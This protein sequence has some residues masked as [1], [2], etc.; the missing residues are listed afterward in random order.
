MSLVER[1]NDEERNEL[2]NKWLENVSEI[3]SETVSL[4]ID[5]DRLTNW[6][7]EN[8]SIVKYKDGT[9]K[10]DLSSRQ[11]PSKVYKHINSIMQSWG[12]ELKSIEIN[13]GGSFINSSITWDGI[14]YIRMKLNSFH[15]DMFDLNGSW[16]TYDQYTIE[17]VIEDYMIE[18]ANNSKELALQREIKIRSLMK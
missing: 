18:R 16:E 11:V 17:S 12:L 7:R 1:Y 8:Y 4:A 10:R 5:G 2:I 13:K 3:T 6:D 14:T 15:T 9:I